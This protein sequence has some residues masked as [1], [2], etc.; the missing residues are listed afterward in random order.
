[1]NSTKPQANVIV[2][3]LPAGLE[4][5]IADNLLSLN[6]RF[7]QT[8]KIAQAILKMSDFYIQNPTA[9]TPWAEPWAQVAQWAYYLPLN[10]LRNV[11]VVAEAQRQEFF[12][13]LT[14]VVDFGAGLGAGFRSLPDS[15]KSFQVIEKSSLALQQIQSS[16]IISEKNFVFQKTI[17]KVKNPKKTL[18][19]FSY[20]LTELE[21]IPAWALETEA[22]MIL[23]PSTQQDGRRLQAW[24]EDLIAKGFHIWAP[25]T[26]HLACPLLVHSKKDWCH[27]RLHFQRPSWLERIELKLPWKNQTLTVS[28]LLARKKPKTR[29]EGLT[30]IVGDSLIEKG[31]TKQLI[32]KND[33][34]EFLS[35]LHKNGSAPDLHRGDL[36]SWSS[37]QAEIKGNEIRLM[38][39]LKIH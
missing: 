12:L 1:M 26:H 14:E 35:W 15:F 19:L 36:V 33:L 21:S 6:Y 34:R 32:C 13:D 30:R 23:E 37:D 28:Y 8:D 18:S 27:H 24:R 39:D 31:K 4:A 3:H 22:L 2:H 9:Q 7:E 16:Q 17:D 5:L 10:Y 38:A 25:C 29:S 20:S 11:A